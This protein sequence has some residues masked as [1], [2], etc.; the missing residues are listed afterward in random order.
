MPCTPPR[1]WTC[2]AAV[3]CICEGGMGAIAGTL[4]QAVRQ[5]GGQVRYRQEVTRIVVERGQAAGVET[6][7]G[8]FIPAD[9]VV[10]NLPPWNIAPL[11]GEHAPARLRSLPPRPDR[12]LGRVHGLRW[13]GRNRRC[14]EIFLCITRSSCAS[15]WAKATASSCRSVRPGTRAAA[16]ASRRAVTISTHTNLAPWWELFDTDRAAYE[17]RKAAYAERLLHAAERALPSLRAAADLVLPGTPVTFQRFTRRA[18]G[19]VGGFPQTNLFR[20]WGPRLAGGLWMVG[21]SIFP[22]NRPLP[23]HWAGCGSAL[24]SWMPQA[25]LSTVFCPKSTTAVQSS[26]PTR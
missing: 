20:A 26:A 16:P 14:P 25:S 11:L 18:W 24:P 9:L 5:N 22:A 15:R 3:W 4:A 19:W 2:R 12:W 7:R 6:K 1:R 8:E 10:A 17:A 13:V 23:W 21:D